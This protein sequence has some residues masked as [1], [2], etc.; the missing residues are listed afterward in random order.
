MNSPTASKVDLSIIVPTLNEAG[1]IQALYQEIQQALD[2]VRWQIIFVDDDSSDDTRANIRSRIQ[3]VA[4][5]WCIVS[6]GVDSHPH[7]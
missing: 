5:N 6:A 2:D 4:F 7:A 3:T 1:N